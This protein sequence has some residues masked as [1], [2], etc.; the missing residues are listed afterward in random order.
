MGTILVDSKM[1]ARPLDQH[2][3]R[4]PLAK[5][6]VLGSC[7]Q[8]GFYSDSDVVLYSDLDVVLDAFCPPKFDWTLR[9]CS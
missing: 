8:H 5:A 7:Y 4:D 6:E 2:G 3:T 9:P 1:I